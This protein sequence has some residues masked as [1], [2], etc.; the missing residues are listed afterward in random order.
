MTSNVCM[1]FFLVSDSTNPNYQHDVYN[2]MATVEAGIRAV[3]A[4]FSR[5]FDYK[6]AIVMGKVFFLFLNFLQYLFF[7][8][9]FSVS[10]VNEVSLFIR[11][12]NERRFNF[13]LFNPSQT[14]INIGY[15]F[16]ATL[17]RSALN[18]SRGYRVST[19]INN[20]MLQTW[21][22]VFNFLQD[23]Q[24]CPF[25]RYNLSHYDTTARRYR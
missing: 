1:C 22:E 14:I 13:V 2:Q 25:N 17:S 11:R 15:R 18:T 9:F 6:L 21:L 5:Y 10:D 16:M 7:F 4:F 24:R 12:P 3:R 20:P 19:N 23:S 8:L